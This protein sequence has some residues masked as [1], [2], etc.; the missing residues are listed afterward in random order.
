[1]SPEVALIMIPTWMSIDG[2][3]KSDGRDYVLGYWQGS[4]ERVVLKKWKCLHEF[5][6]R[7]FEDGELSFDHKCLRVRAGTQSVSEG[8]THNSHSEPHVLNDANVMSSS[9]LRGRMRNS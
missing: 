2:Q 5:K 7:A 4:H 3:T 1:M 8:T 9:N 6:R